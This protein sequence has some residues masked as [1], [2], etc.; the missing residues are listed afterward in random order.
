VSAGWVWFP[1]GVYSGAWVSWSVTPTY[2]GWC[3][4]DYYNRP[5]YVNNHITNVTVNNYGG[6]WNFLPLNR[7]S[8]RN[9]ARLIV[10]A[11]RVPNLHG[12]VT[13]RVLP[14]F[15]PE[16]A[17]LRP[18]VSRQILRESAKHQYRMEALGTE[19]RESLVPFRQADRREDRFQRQ[20]LTGR[21][22]P[23][24]RSSAP[25]TPV[26]PRAEGP[27]P[28]VGAGPS[29]GKTP[30][31]QNPHA[32][33]G[34]RREPAGQGPRRDGLGVARERG[35]AT[36]TGGSDSGTVIR[37]ESQG[38]QDGATVR[39]R[40][41]PTPPAESRNSQDASRRVLQRILGKGVDSSSGPSQPGV[42]P[43]D[44]SSAP[45]RGRPSRERVQ[46]PRQAAPQ[47]RVEANRPRS[48]PQRQPPPAPPRK[49]EE[50]KDKP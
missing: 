40:R 10:K 47:P 36:P 22:S 43:R 4:L 12:A 31:V 28:R 49:Q 39:P 38:R 9:A 13:T 45:D 35:R 1:G 3:P 8:D 46:A 30:G 50:K 16:Q 21:R 23:A 25:A 11:D 24:G 29:D 41:E 5:A 42:K 15:S 17:R 27:K 14:R 6:G 37:K 44:G 18:D 48:Q 26:A 32:T 7:F 19:S 34:T 33:P 2:I 20:A